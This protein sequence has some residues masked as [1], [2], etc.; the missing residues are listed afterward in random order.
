MRQCRDILLQFADP[1]AHPVFFFVI[2]QK[3][4]ERNSRLLK[5][6]P[7]QITVRA[8]GNLKK[9]AALP[10]SHRK[11]QIR[12]QIFRNPVVIEIR[13]GI[14]HLERDLCFHQFLY[15]CPAAKIR[16]EQ[17]RHL[18]IWTAVFLRLPQLLGNGTHLLARVLISPDC[19]RSAFRVV[20]GNRLF[21]PLF[22]VVD[23]ALGPLHNKFRTTVIFIEHYLRR[24][25]VIFRKIHHDLRLGPAELINRLIVIPDNKEVIFRQ[26]QHPHNL[27]L[28]GA[29]V[30]KLVNQDILKFL[31][32]GAKDLR[33]LQKETF[34][35]HHQ[36]V[37]I[38]F[39]VLLPPFLIRLI[40]FAEL[41]LRHTGGI[42]M[43]QRDLIVLH[44]ADFT[45]Q[46]LLEIF[47]LQVSGIVVDQLAHQPLFLF[48]A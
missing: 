24:A 6:I 42:V 27:I 36:I 15:C 3:C 38:E 34:A 9:L 48:L 32:P 44:S 37:E 22:V 20:G 4:I 19:N 43:F 40:D 39:F 11:I 41:L 21:I 28:H 31:L 33:P 1:L 2:F 10:A 47:F 26:R 23:Q 17:K 12:Q 45:R 25:R 46:I 18:F 7:R 16:A 5:G 30:L 14:P 8:V 29:D 13:Q 35:L